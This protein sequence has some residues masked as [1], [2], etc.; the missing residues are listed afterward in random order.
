MGPAAEW[1]PASRA[2]RRGA[3]GVVSRPALWGRL[4]EAARVTVVSAPPGSGK[5]VLLRSWIGAAGLAERAAWVPV[6]R[7]ELDP[8]RL[9]LAVLDALRQTAP[10]SALVRPLTAAPDLDG[11]AIVE[12]LLTDLAPLQDQLWLVVDDAHELDSDEARRQ[13]ELPWT[14]HTRPSP[15]APP[16]PCSWTR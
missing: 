2:A 13:L 14:P 11:W 5:T 7:D 12:R 4:A 10:G 1:Q 9:W 3:G 15:V 6:G 16:A 8:Q